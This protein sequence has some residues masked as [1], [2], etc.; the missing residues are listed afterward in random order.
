MQLPFLLGSAAQKDVQG[1]P[2]QGDPCLSRWQ[3]LGEHCI[4]ESLGDEAG[5]GSQSIR[6]ALS[7]LALPLTPSINKWTFFM[8]KEGDRIQSFL[9]SIGQNWSFSWGFFPFFRLPWCLLSLVWSLGPDSL[10]SSPSPS[11]QWMT[12]GN[13]LSFLVFICLEKTIQSLGIGLH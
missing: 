2:R 3:S 7:H 11:T 4:R 5:V 6:L 8:G 12:L 13:L 10:G 9:Q 1:S